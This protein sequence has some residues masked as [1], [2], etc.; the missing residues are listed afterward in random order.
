MA[1]S[2]FPFSC[3]KGIRPCTLWI[4]IMDLMTVQIALGFGPKRTKNLSTLRTPSFEPQ[5]A[6]VGILKVIFIDF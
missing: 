5:K 6:V 2:L 3:L 1:D 4:P